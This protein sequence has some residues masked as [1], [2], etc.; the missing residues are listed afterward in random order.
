MSCCGDEEKDLTT[1]DATDIPNAVIETALDRID[2]VDYGRLFEDSE[3]TPIQDN[4]GARGPAPCCVSGLQALEAGIPANEIQLDQ[5]G[6]RILK[7]AQRQIDFQ[8]IMGNGADVNKVQ[9]I[10]YYQNQRYFDVNGRVVVQFPPGPKN[11]NWQWTPGAD[12]WI[13][14][15]E[16]TVRCWPNFGPQTQQGLQRNVAAAT[17]SWYDAPGLSLRGVVT[18][19]RRGI[20]VPGQ[21]PLSL[22][23]DFKTDILCSDVQLCVPDTPA[24]RIRLQG[25]WANDVVARVT[26]SFSLSIQL[27]MVRFNNRNFRVPVIPAAAPSRI[28]NINRTIL[29]PC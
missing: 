22:S 7:S 18:D 6:L 20:L 5:N 1:I 9:V 17:V 27:R 12:G 15:S 11:A 10:Q 23:I 29:K 13:V 28:L 16:D 26:W 21:F 14:D 8:V 2:T 4:A 19:F 3:G 24:A 25:N